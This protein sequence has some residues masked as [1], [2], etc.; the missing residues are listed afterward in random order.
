MYAPVVSRFH[1]YSWPLE[2]DVAAY[3]KAV[4]ELPAYRAWQAAANA[5][6]WVI[7]TYEYVE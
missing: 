1:T 4:R 6:P 3:A 5:E 7:D 2:P